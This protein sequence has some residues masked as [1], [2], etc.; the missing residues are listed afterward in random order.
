MLHKGLHL[1]QPVTTACS[2]VH[3]AVCSVVVRQAIND[4]A[5]KGLLPQHNAYN[6]R[7]GSQSASIYHNTLSDCAMLELCNTG[8]RRM[9]SYNITELITAII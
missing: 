9:R 2:S 8:S 1:A 6:I 4:M 7:K 5:S 3:S